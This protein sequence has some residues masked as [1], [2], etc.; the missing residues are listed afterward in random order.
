VE[1][2]TGWGDAYQ[3]GPDAHLLDGPGY[4]RH[5]A[6]VREH[7]F[8]EAGG[9]ALEHLGDGEARGNVTVCFVAFTRV[10]GL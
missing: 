8:Q 7:G 2:K 6:P 3:T 5:A 10:G 9:P 1:G 4:V